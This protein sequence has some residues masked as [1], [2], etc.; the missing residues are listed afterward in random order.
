MADEQI[1]AAMF[2]EA[3]LRRPAMYTMNGTFAEVVAFLNGYYSGAA[4]GHLD[5]P[6]VIEWTDLE[7]WLANRLGV[8]STEAFRRI[9]QSFDD[10]C[11][12]ID[13][14]ADWYARFRYEWNSDSAA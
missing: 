2:T 10:N 5:W 9:E 4:R 3:V 13:A 7:R 14:L 8:A 6:P 11:E 1:R 12:R